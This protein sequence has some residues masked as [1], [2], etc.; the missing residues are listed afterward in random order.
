VRRLYKEI[1]S[2]PRARRAPISLDAK[3]QSASRHDRTEEPAVAFP[4]SLSLRDEVI[5]SGIK[6]SLSL[7]SKQKRVAKTHFLQHINSIRRWLIRPNDRGSTCA[8]TELVNWPRPI[9][10]ARRGCAMGREHIFKNKTH[11]EMDG[12]SGGRACGLVGVVPAPQ[13][14]HFSASTPPATPFYISYVGN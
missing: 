13:P 10:H 7:P 4:E 12:K 9:Y 1:W 14:N 2:I 8:P 3:T 5:K 11:R 6:S